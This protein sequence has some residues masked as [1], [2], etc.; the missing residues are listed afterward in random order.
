MPAE[1]SNDPAILLARAAKLKRFIQLRRTRD[2]ALLHANIGAHLRWM[3]A[4][5]QDGHIMLSGPVAPGDGE[6][7]LDGLTIIR[8]ASLADAHALAQ[9]DPFIK[10][11]AVSYELREWTVNEGALTVTLSLSDSTVRIA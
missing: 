7:Q 9:Q 6:V 3:I 1:P 11:G 10:L 2:P 4:A 8:A 5:E